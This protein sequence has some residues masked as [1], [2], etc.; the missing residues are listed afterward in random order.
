MATARSDLAPVVP[1]FRSKRA[2]LEWACEK[3]PGVFSERKLGY[4]NEPFHWEW[5]ELER[6]YDRLAIVAPREHAKSE[7]FSVNTTAHKAIYEPGSWQH[8]FSSTIP[9]AHELVDRTVQAIARAAPWMLDGS[10]RFT[11]SDM[12]FSNW[13][14]ITVGSVGRATR[15]LH[16]DRIVGDDVLDEL[17]TMT[18]PAASAPI[19]PEPPSLG[20]YRQQKSA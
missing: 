16:P 13:S 1:L 18:N 20:W 4:V 10:P 5:Y 17:R 15:G 7:I 2:S 3:H 8:L 9:L 19:W 14:R 6:R 11:K 12:V